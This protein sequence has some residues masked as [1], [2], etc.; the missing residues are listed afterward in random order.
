MSRLA[1]IF[2]TT[3]IVALSSVAPETVDFLPA[4][5]IAGPNPA[6]PSVA[7]VGWIE[8][9]LE[10]GVTGEGGVRQITPLRRSSVAHDLVAPA[11]MQWRFRPAMDAGQPVPSHVLVAA[12]FRPPDMYNNAT[13]GEPAITVGVPS[14]DMPF[15]EASPPP[16]YPP[17]DVADAVVVVELAVGWYGQVR[18]ARTVVGVPGFER[19]SLDAARRWI[20]RPARRNGRNVDSYVYLVFGF[21]RPLTSGPTR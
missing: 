16:P 6:L 10:I 14:A 7:V 5:R 20:F 15:P 21:R 12:V 11:V 17:L 18:R 3:L 1:R 9:I 2:L 8:E 4:R 19:A 13:L